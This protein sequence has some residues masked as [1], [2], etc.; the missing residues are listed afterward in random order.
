MEIN[1]I[2]TNAIRKEIQ[3]KRSS[4][5]IDTLITYCQYLPIEEAIPNEFIRKFVKTC[6]FTILQ[7]YNK[8][9]NYVLDNES[10]YINCYEKTLLGNMAK[11]SRQLLGK[12]TINTEEELKIYLENVIRVMRKSDDDIAKRLINENKKELSTMFPN[13]FLDYNLAEKLLS[14]VDENSR[15]AIL[16]ALELGFNGNSEMLSKII[17]EY[18]SLISV[19]EN[20]DIIIS[21]I[22]YQKMFYLLGSKKFLEINSVYG[23]AISHL[24]SHT[25]MEDFEKLL[26]ELQNNENFVDILNNEVYK[27]IT[28][29]R[30]F[31]IRCLPDSFKKSHPELYLE[32]NAPE[33]LVNKFYGLSY[34]YFGTRKL[35]NPA[36]L[37]HNPDWIQYLKHVDLD[38][39][40]DDKQMAVYN[41]I[42][43]R[44][45]HFVQIRSF[46]KALGIKFTQEEIL[47][48]FSIYGDILWN[49]NMYHFS[50]DLGLEKDKCYEF[51]LA[52]MYREIVNRHS[53]IRKNMPEEFKNKYS[54]LFLEENAPEELQNLFYQRQ[55][56]PEI[57]QLHPEWVQFLI[58]KNIRAVC[59][60]NILAFVNSAEF[61]ELTNKRVLELFEEY[62]NYLLTYNIK[63]TAQA[64]GNEDEFIKKHI[65]ESIIQKRTSYDASIKKFIG[66]ECPDLFLDE[67]A[68]EE[69]KK[70]FYNSSNNTP[71]TFELLKQHKEWIPFLKDKNV[72]LSLKKKNIGI[73]GLEQLFEK[74]GEE[75]AIRIGMKNPES[76]MKMLENNKFELFS[77]WY[78]KLNFIPHYVVMMEFPIEKSDS[79]ISSG[80]KWSQLMRIERH[81]LNEESKSALLKA[82]MCFGVFDN[83]MDG[84]NKVMQLF[85]DVPKILSENEMQDLIR[86][87]EEKN[88]DIELVNKVYGK[89]ENGS[90]TLKINSQQNKDVINVIRG[91]MEQVGFKKV[92]SPDLAHKLFGG[93]EMKYEPEFRDFLLKNIET[94]LESDDY[95]AYISSMQ[96]QWPEIKALNSN[97]VLTLDLALAFVKS[98]N[99]QD[100]QIG[101]EKLAEVANQAGYNQQDFETLQQI[102]NY[103]KVRIF[104]SIPRIKNTSDQ[105]TYEVLRLDDPLAVA[106]GTL[107][108]CCQELGNVAE[109]CMEHSMVSEYGRI[110]VIKDELGNVFQVG[111]P[112]HMS[113]RGEI[114]EWYLRTVS[115]VVQDVS[116][117]E[118]GEY[119][120]LE[121][122]AEVDIEI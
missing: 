116:I 59:D 39:C 84:F 36:D 90:Y 62:G 122:V 113:F 92:L 58:D 44:E 81:N 24:I 55:I 57:I 78:D 13:Q 18:P 121:Y 110:F 11:H 26:I 12:F 30:D 88:G 72:L 97:R 22:L 65:I 52:R 69:L 54:D 117:N 111:N 34:S 85:T 8:K 68:P 73:R 83:D 42:D 118:I 80:K 17:N 82:S 28:S 49:Y 3:D 15:S 61:I 19:I 98:N 5:D 45:E 91:I 71:L 43:G 16:S 56:S 77:Q 112:A 104:N 76:V 119:V 6:G 25:K 115:L 102:Y 100:V 67:N 53:I 31:D 93:F 94:I 103:G 89:S 107:T 35:I 47:A 75:N 14:E 63:L 120:H 32:D 29:K 106:I 60:Y 23:N 38:K 40:L 108:D 50:L 87:I 99:Y 4:N 109:T 1:D 27:L 37:Q 95:I 70:Y 7:N 10:L 74:Y 105:Y 46:Y 96:K 2:I 101:N 51:L 114:P 86:L 33:S 48:M 66:S 21:G 64:I 9:N 20:K 79:F 41:S